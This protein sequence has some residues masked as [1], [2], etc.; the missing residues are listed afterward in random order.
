[1]VDVY[2]LVPC[3][4]LG[5]DVGA[6]YELDHFDLEFWRERLLE[7]RL[8]LKEEYLWLTTCLKTNSSP[9]KI[10]GWKIDL[11]LG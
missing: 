3:V 2:R 11:F 8:G 10:N 9:L 5:S 7:D 4:F 6:T 1:M